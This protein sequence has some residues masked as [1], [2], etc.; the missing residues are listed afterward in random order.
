MIMVKA[1][2]AEFAHA[3]GLPTWAHH[4]H[5]CFACFCTG[6]PE[7]NMR[8]FQNVSPVGLPWA[9]KDATSYEAACARCEK[10]VL[11]GSTNQLQRLLGC[12]AYDKRRGGSGA[13]GRA[14]T[15]DFA[16]LG[17]LKGMRLEPC[18]S[19]PDVG[20]LDGATV[21][22]GGLQL[23]FWDRRADTLTR[24]RNPLL[25]GRTGITCQSL[26]ADEMHTLFLGVFQDYIAATL[27]QAIV[28]DVY[29]VGQGV[30]Q[31]VA[32]Q[33]SVQRMRKYLH[34][35]YKLQRKMCPDRP[36]YELQHFEV[37]T[38]G[39]ATHRTL[40]AK[41]AESGTLLRFALAVAEQHTNCLTRG[42][43]LVKAGEALVQYMD[44]TR[45]AG[46][47]LAP[48][49]RQGLVDSALRFCSLREACDIPFKPKQ[50]LWLHLVVGAGHF[51]NPRLTATWVDEGLNMQLA[52]VCRS[53]ASRVWNRRVLATFSH[54]AGP[55]AKAAAKHAADLASGLEKADGGKK[56]KQQTIK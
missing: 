41:A 1:D 4:A 26:V 9:L 36:I 49:A 43:S 35:W 38:L 18:A 29:N 22:V 46:W 48:S 52:A 24:H 12:L 50:H 32:T 37:S 20:M 33:L 45:K 3:L 39:T 10:Y 42:R 53:S 19:L 47:R 17:L 25:N 5:P 27:W 16:E 11:V 44:I 14:L 28:E 7:G 40:K 31:E 51:G 54:P 55:T 21:P 8:D 30:P 56:E 13:G 15:K 6:G 2:W 34:M 23:L